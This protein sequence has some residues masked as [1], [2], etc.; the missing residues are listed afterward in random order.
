MSGP[1]RR[2]R[3]VEGSYRAGNVLPQPK[4]VPR[5]PLEAAVQGTRRCAAETAL[6]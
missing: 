2:L 3:L 4:P 6:D 1:T 5:R